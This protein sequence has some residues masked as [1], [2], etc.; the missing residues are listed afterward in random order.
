M[1][2]TWMIRHVL[3]VLALVVVSVTGFEA[4]SAADAKQS[5]LLKPGV[6]ANLY[7]QTFEAISGSSQRDRQTQ[8]RI[9]RVQAERLSTGNRDTVQPSVSLKPSPPRRSESTTAASS[10]SPSCQES[11]D[12]NLTTQELV[13]TT[14]GQQFITTPIT[15][16]RPGLRT[17]TGSFSIFLKEQNVYFY[18]PWPQG[19]PNYYPPLFVAYAMEFLDGGY[20]LHT[21]PDEPSGAFG[22]G[23]QDG[24]YASHGCVHVPYSVMVKLFSSATDGTP[25]TIHY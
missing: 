21:D 14:C 2:F 1:K 25:V 9:A 7:G 3:A 5:R 10:S 4:A 23:S 13:A 11:I 12:V 22:P 17:P 16:G 24:P 19:D 8:D 18:S 15:S 20:F 6:A